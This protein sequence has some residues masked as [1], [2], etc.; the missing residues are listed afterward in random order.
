M[1]FVNGQTATF[2]ININPPNA[3][4]FS[5]ALNVFANTGGVSAGVIANSLA[6]ILSVVPS[7]LAFPDTVVGTQA[8]SQNVVITNLSPTAI[9]LGPPMFSLPEFAFTSAPSFPVSLAP[10]ASLTLG[11]TVT[12]QLPGPHFYTLT[13]LTNI[14]N[15]E[16][17]IGAAVV[18]VSFVVVN[19]LRGTN[20][21]F[22]M[23]YGPVSE[24][25]QV[26]PTDVN[27]E[28]G[29]LMIFNGT[30]WG[31]IS[32]EKVIRR[33]QFYY[34]NLGQCVLT[35]TATVQ[36][37]DRQGNVFTDSQSSTV[38]IGTPTPDGLEYS[39]FFDFQLAG[40]IVTLTI[41]RA[42]STG[43]CSLYMFVPS[44]EDKG[45]KVELV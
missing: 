35:A 24:T 1:Q 7:S 16:V 4:S 39:S 43:P 25:R 8:P 5:G 20:Y 42:P 9:T 6:G 27:S 19:A 3:G 23:G 37:Y 26:N 12:P 14:I 33:L 11:L 22:L 36:R 17:V 45:E 31:A 2:F 29:Q 15:T 41:T 38:T 28:L 34:E 30:L 10:N 40:E 18:A 13:I 32:S 21:I 44:I